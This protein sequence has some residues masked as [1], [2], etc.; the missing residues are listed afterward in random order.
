MS[1]S[2]I[3][4]CLALMLGLCLSGCVSLLPDAGEDAAIYDLPVPQRSPAYNAPRHTAVLKI[5]NIVCAQPHASARILVRSIKADIV[6]DEPLAGALWS[7]PL[8]DLISHRL[9]ES[10]RQSHLFSG[11]T[12]KNDPIDATYLLS[13]TVNSFELRP[14]DTSLEAH[15]EM[16]FLLSQHQ[17]RR[18][19]E[20]RT[21]GARVPA[22][23]LS[24]D[25][26]ITALSQA[27]SKVL[28]DLRSW[29]ASRSLKPT[30]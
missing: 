28:E 23:S 29:L 13:T 17:D 25:A 4:P 27:F 2:H 18:L 14:T 8:P 5:A 22:A 30:R 6:R 11:V 15:V 12:Q 26:G 3:L 10:L 24:K 7:E 20:S 1:V 16:T 19:L 9:V 21:I